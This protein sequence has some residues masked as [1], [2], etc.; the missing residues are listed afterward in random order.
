MR[1]DF[2]AVLMDVQMPV[3]DGYE[4]T[5]RIRANPAFRGIPV[6]AMTANAME[7]DQRLA[8]EAGMTDH[9][10]KPIDPA[11]LFRKLAFHVKADASKPFDSVPEAGT[12]GAAPA[13]DAVDLPGA[14][15]GVDIAAGLGH[16]A[17]NRAAYRRL[18]LQFCSLRLL[19]DARAALAAGD[20]EA[21]VRD[22]HSLK[23][24]SGNLGAKELSRRAAQIEAA[25]RAGTET[26]GPL[27][28]L[29]AHGREVVEGIRAWEASAAGC[30]G[31]AKP[32]LGE[33]ALFRGLGELRILV[34]D[35]DV[36]ALELCEALLAESPAE[37]AEHLRGARDALA[38][39]DFD[40][41]LARVDDALTGVNATTPR[42]FVSGNV[43]SR[44]TWSSM[45]GSTVGL[46]C[47]RT[48]RTPSL[49]SDF[50]DT[51]IQSV[52]ATFRDHGE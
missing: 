31:S 9:V 8:L 6:I 7:Q 27:D 3:M 32:A 29:L 28:A 44:P 30:P 24:V 52:N 46:T 48:L 51:W 45:A 1:T 10:A 12:V 2:H 20:K 36:S 19:D 17:G 43:D 47:P 34:A 41:A 16:L 5:R 23:S 38:G 14:L 21:A 42:R 50:P 11:Q 40:A 25:L 33:E 22:I 13:A 37:T 35:S 49:H 39:Y 26:A 4:A 15:P 18:L